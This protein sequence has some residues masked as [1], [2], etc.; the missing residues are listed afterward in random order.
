[1]TVVLLI[2]LVFDS[3]HVKTNKHVSRDKYSG[4]SYIEALVDKAKYISRVQWTEN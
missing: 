1:M 2:E 4:I 3:K